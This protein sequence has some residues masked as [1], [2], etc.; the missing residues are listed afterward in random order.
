MFDQNCGT[1]A[2]LSCSQSEYRVVG[3]EGRGGR[4]VVTTGTMSLDLRTDQ[5]GIF[6]PNINTMF[7]PPD[8]SHFNLVFLFSF[9]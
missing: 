1:S 2:A 7:R 4:L 3:E 9:N 8:I 5:L 6:Q